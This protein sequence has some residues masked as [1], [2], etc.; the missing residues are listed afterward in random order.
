M[1]EEVREVR[2]FEASAVGKAGVDADCGGGGADWSMDLSSWS[3]AAIS[4]C[5][6]SA[7]GRTI[8]GGSGRDGCMLEERRGRECWCLSREEYDGI[9]G[10]R[11][12]GISLSSEDWKLPRN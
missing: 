7:L 3:W 6:G 5:C 11:L 9:G 8:G 12:F 4:E 10:R 1:L 2:G